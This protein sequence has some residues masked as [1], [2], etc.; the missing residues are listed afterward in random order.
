MV[1]A[2]SESEA[3]EN[4]GRVQKLVQFLYP[5]YENVQEAQT[6]S[7]GPLVRLKVMNLLQNLKNAGDVNNASKAKSPEDFYKAYKS[8]GPDPNLGQ[9]GFINSLT[10]NHNIGQR[11]AGVFEKVDRR[12]TDRAAATSFLQSPNQGGVTAVNT[13]LPK[14]IEL[15]INFTPIHE[16]PLGW[17][18]KGRFAERSAAKDQKVAANMRANGEM[19]PYGIITSSPATDEENASKTG[20][21]A[22]QET[23]AAA[24]SEQQ[25]QNAEA[26]YGGMFG[27]AREN[28]DRRHARRAQ[29][30][31]AEALGDF[32]TS[33]SDRDARRYARQTAKSTYLNE[34]LEGTAGGREDTRTGGSS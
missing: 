13:I 1:P 24:R 5:N 22:E 8:I 11:D 19:F 26:R 28:R 27:G 9:L 4:L 32:Q 17:N 33:L 18:N 34:Q 10:V 3:F 2:A 20:E 29:A 16:H 14:N 12:G 23:A 25:K 6:I 15:V 30:A 7:Q 21:E 31:A